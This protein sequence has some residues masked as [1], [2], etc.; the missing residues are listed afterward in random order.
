MRYESLN[1]FKSVAIQKLFVEPADQN[2]VL[3][4]WMIANGFWPECYW[5][6]SQALEKYLKACLAA[7]DLPIEMGSK[8]H[9]ICALYERVKSIHHNLMPQ[10][11]T[12]PQEL[13]FEV[14]RDESTERSLQR[15]HRMG[16]ANSRYALESWRALS[17]DIFKLDQLCFLFRRLTIGLE[18]IVGEDWKVSSRELPFAGMNYLAALT[19]DRY[20]EPRGRLCGLD[21]RVIDIGETRAEILHSW[22]FAFFRTEND[23]DKP[24]P[25]HFFSKIGPLQNSHIFLLW[26][27]L[28]RR[29]NGEPVEIDPIIKD[30]LLWLVNYVPKP[31]ANNIRREIDIPRPPWKSPEGD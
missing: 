27:I 1:H 13:H 20:F 25:L 28:T 15:F 24:P 10:N 9:D 18:W 26:S 5:Q 17:D 19:M 30:G 12:K 7:N 16:N 22:N 11:L 31:I 3:A 21:K 29:E 4:R 14:W 8:G 2:Y 23:L 6:S